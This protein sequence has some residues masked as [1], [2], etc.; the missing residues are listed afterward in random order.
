MPRLCSCE[1]EAISSMIS[2]TRVTE[3]TT[4][5]I[6]SPAR[7][8]SVLPVLI[9]F[10]DSSINAAIS[11]AACALRCERLRTSAATTAKPR[12]CSPARA[13][14]TAAFSARILVWKEIL[15]ITSVMSAIL[16]ELAEI[17]C[18]VCTTSRTTPPPRPAVCEA[19]A[20]IWLAWRALSALF[21]TVAVSCSMLAAVCTT[22]LD[23]CSVRAASALLPDAI[24]PAVWVIRPTL[25]RSSPVISRRRAFIRAIAPVS[26]PNSSWR[27]VA[28]CALRSPSAIRSASSRF[29]IS[30]RTIWR[31]M[32]QAT[33]TPVTIASAPR[34]MASVE[35]PDVSASF[36]ALVSKTICLMAALL[37]SPA[38]FT[39]FS[40]PFSASQ[41]V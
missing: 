6:V 34:R 5:S 12:P 24:S 10:T 7:A 9:R 26:L 39:A 18:M 33:K 30:G 19:V 40:A 14:S 32:A 28:I 27:S 41:A 16:R 11:F 35:E 25:A 4:S 38:F 8:A 21:F 22:A 23:C 13:A 2:F 17:S 37:L 20:A 3:C 15:F 1:A 31:V 36:C 29:I